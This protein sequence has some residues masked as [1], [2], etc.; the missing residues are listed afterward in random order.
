[1]SFPFEIVLWHPKML[2]LLAR[3]AQ[4]TIAATTD[5]DGQ[6]SAPVQSG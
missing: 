5:G 4:Y 1:M 6:E 2:V 3:P